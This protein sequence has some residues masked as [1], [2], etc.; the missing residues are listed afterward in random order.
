[1]RVNKQENK[2]ER[3]RENEGE[4]EGTGRKMGEGGL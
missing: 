4:E 1:M 2:I 3:G